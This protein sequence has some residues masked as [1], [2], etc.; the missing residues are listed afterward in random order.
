M[1]VWVFAGGGEAEARGLIPFLQ[2]Q[3]PHCRFERKFPVGL[4][5]NPKKPHTYR[6][7]E[8]YKSKQ[9]SYARGATGINL[10]AQITNRLRDSFAFNEACDA[11][12]IIDDLDCRNPETQTSLFQE[13]VAVVPQ[14]QEM[15]LV[16]GFAAPELE[17]WIIA[18]WSGV[19][20][21]H[22]RFSPHSVTMQRWL[23]QER[24][25]SF[26]NPE[27]FS[28]YDAQKDSC[29]EKLS[30]AIQDCAVTVAAEYYAKGEDTPYLIKQLNPQVVVQKCPHFRRLHKNLSDFCAD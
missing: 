4:K 18:D 27:G 13:A 9:K 15:A 11:I 20:A 16:I 17:S 29:R 10:A 22:V 6:S 25:V 30:Q 5:T 28:A 14:T 7:D 1:V 23:E 8:A 21:R 3:F 26:A 2:A 12:L 19:M 24:H